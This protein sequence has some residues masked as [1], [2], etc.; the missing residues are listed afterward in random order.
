MERTQLSW[1]WGTKVRR[2]RGRVSALV[3]HGQHSLISLLLELNQALVWCVCVCLF[4]KPHQTGQAVFDW[5]FHGWVVFP[6]PL[7]AFLIVI[8]E[9]DEGR[10]CGRDML[11]GA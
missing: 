5:R 2:V 8:F 4:L 3:S 1:L 6:R 9:I 10:L 11:A 7:V